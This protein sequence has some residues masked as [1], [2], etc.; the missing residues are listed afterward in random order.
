MK[1]FRESKRLV[2]V[3][4][5]LDRGRQNVHTTQ[6]KV[7]STMKMKRTILALSTCAILSVGF[8]Q[9]GSL[10]ATSYTD[11]NTAVDKDT[12]HIMVDSQNQDELAADF[13]LPE[14]TI[15]TAEGIQLIVNAF[16]LNLDGI[17]FV[18]MP[19]ASDYFKNANNNAWYANALIIAANQGFELP[20]DLDPNKMWTKEEFVYQLMH[21]MESKKALP[22]INVVPAKLADESELT[23]A[24]QGAIQRALALGFTKVDEKGNFN[25]KG[26]IS[27]K[28]SAELIQ[29][30]LEYVKARTLPAQQ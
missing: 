2:Y 5:L 10:A 3:K 13:F 20:A 25:P 6:E 28:E 14:A 4:R 22:M 15:T 18:K 8:I 21:V 27:R 29:R 24:Y 17:R 23:I 26:E 11:Q 19:V 16:D 7:V 12:V 30:S 9:Q 1:L